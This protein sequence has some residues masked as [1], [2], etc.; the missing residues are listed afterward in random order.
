MNARYGSCRSRKRNQHGFS[1]VELVVA[2]GISA[3]LVASLVSVV[4]LSTRSLALS[5]SPTAERNSAM[6]ALHHVQK[7]LRRALDFESVS[8]TR[9]RFAVPDRDGDQLPEWI[10]Y[11]WVGSPDYELRKTVELS[12]QGPGA[13]YE[14]VANGVLTFSFSFLQEQQGTA[15]SVAPERSDEMLLFANQDLPD[16][17][18]RK[19]MM[20]VNKSYQLTT[21][22]QEWKS[23]LEGWGFSVIPV[24]KDN[25][26]AQLTT[27]LLK[28]DAILVLD[29]GHQLKWES[30]LV[31]TNKGV[32][33]QTDTA[34]EYLGFA[35]LPSQSNLLRRAEWKSQ[36]HYITSD[37]LPGAQ[38]LFTSTQD[39]YPL[40]NDP[41]DLAPGLAVLANWQDEPA[42]GAI[43][44]GDDLFVASPVQ[45]EGGNAQQFAQQT[46]PGVDYKIITANRVYLSDKALVQNIS[47]YIAPDQNS[48]IRMGIYEDI[49][50]NPGPLIAETDMKAVSNTGWQTANVGP[51]VV[52]DAGWYWLAVGVGYGIRLHYEDDAASDTVVVNWSGD[53][54]QSLDPSLDNNPSRLTRKVSIKVGYE[55]I[56]T[57]PGRRV[58]MPWGSATTFSSLDAN[59]QILLQ[60]SLEWAADPT[61][62][63]SAEPLAVSTDQPFEQRIQPSTFPTNAVAWQVDRI[64]VSIRR[65]TDDPS[66]AVRFTLFET[67]GLGNATYL[68]QQS[69]PIPATVWS[70]SE[71]DWYEIPLLDSR[72][73]PIDQALILK[74]ETDSVDP[75][76][77]VQVDTSPETR[78][79]TY[80]YGRFYTE[81]ALQW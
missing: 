79:R 12:T 51:P 7:D 66:A 70:D 67:D 43:D 36:V 69:P 52:I 2:M 3:I 72:Q 6:S 78:L 22:E 38:D 68:W 59:G 37:I 30:V 53:A 10:T 4:H 34:I 64:Y 61:P 58:R 57:A 14:V 1:L 28:P 48:N 19:I 18:T 24:S 11:E 74:V 16:A 25:A 75:T 39:V 23:A 32:V 42:A 40:S 20:I 33:I 17:G 27:D 47:A 21:E 8:A 80:V 29:D 77:E 62:Y 54:T 50:G 5:T 35:R 9:V 73:I 76:V 56:P 49:G 71:F 46:D 31:Q 41:T 81:G 15:A 26:W 45:T 13:P 60:R 65:L 44:I 63:D 55:V